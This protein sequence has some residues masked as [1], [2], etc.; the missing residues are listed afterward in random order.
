MP[1]LDFDIKIQLITF[2][3]INWMRQYHH[4]WKRDLAI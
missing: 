4:P 2:Y 3:L 1:H